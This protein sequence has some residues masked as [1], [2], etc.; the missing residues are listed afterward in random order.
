LEVR[1]GW[2]SI[3]SDCFGMVFVYSRSC[4][5]LQ[6]NRHIPD[7]RRSPL[8]TRNSH[9]FRWSLASRC[10]VQSQFTHNSPLY[11]HLA[12]MNSYPQEVSRPD[13]PQLTLVPGP[14]STSHVCGGVDALIP[15]ESE[16]NGFV[17]LATATGLG[18]Y[19]SR[20]HWIVLATQFDHAARISFNCHCGSSDITS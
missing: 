6:C 16:L 10:W 14:S 11:L 12:N 7:A 8:G 13:Q 3:G 15:R 17:H 9:D 1:I 2:S 18:V 4:P 20:S 19:A 5:I